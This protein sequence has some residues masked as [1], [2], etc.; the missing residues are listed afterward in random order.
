MYQGIFLNFKFFLKYKFKRRTLRLHSHATVENL[1]FLVIACETQLQET[2]AISDQNSKNKMRAVFPP[3]FNRLADM[4]KYKLE[5]YKA[6]FLLLLVIQGSA[7]QWN[8][9]LGTHNLW[10]PKQI[11]IFTSLASLQH[12]TNNLD[13]LP[14]C[15]RKQGDKCA[16]LN[17]FWRAVNHQLKDISSL[18]N[19][20]R[21]NTIICFSTTKWIGQMTCC[22]LHKS[23][24]AIGNRSVINW[25]FL[26]RS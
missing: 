10:L 16:S 17:H 1:S 20:T 25:Y 22:I 12:V 3:F 23:H 24:N 5:R 26:P 7:L 21:A 14:A 13:V 19:N 6:Y 15:L 11:L 18:L 9:F 2:S 8:N 4:K